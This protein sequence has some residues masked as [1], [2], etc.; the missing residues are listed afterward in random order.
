MERAICLSQSRLLRASVI[1]S[2]HFIAFSRIFTRSPAWA[3]MRYAMR[4]AR[5][6]PASGSAR[7]SEGVR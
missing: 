7:C 6:S 2:S 5:T 4:P 1:C 3:A